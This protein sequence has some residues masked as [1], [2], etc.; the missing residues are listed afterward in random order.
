[1]QYVLLKM[2]QDCV[3]WQVTAIFGQPDCITQFANMDN[4]GIAIQHPT[5]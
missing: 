5:A 1:V 4:G 3:E 2:V